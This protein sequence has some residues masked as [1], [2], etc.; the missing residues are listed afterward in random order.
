MN[1][2][3]VRKGWTRAEMEE[4]ES[5]LRARRQRLLEDFRS[6]EEAELNESPELSTLSTH[7]ADMGSDQQAEDLSLGRRESASD[8][9]QDIDEAFER[10]AGGSYGLCDMCGERISKARLEAIPYAKLCL[11]CKQKEEM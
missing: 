5:A 8:E 2:K 7:L 3:T 11:S 10:I 1:A 6:L 9:I 4:F